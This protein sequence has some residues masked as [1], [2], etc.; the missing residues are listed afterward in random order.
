M[1]STAPNVCE[2]NA[3]LLT[4]KYCLVTIKVNSPLLSGRREYWHGSTLTHA[5]PD[6]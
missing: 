1:S 4:P 6:Y 5:R 2:V 3:N